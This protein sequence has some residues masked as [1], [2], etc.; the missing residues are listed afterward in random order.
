MDIFAV[1][2]HRIGEPSSVVKLALPDF[3]GHRALQ[4]RILS[5]QSRSGDPYGFMPWSADP[6]LYEVSDRQD[7]PRK[8]HHRRLQARRRIEG[9]DP[10][11]TMR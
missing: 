2:F 11:F 3:L 1:V 10:A 6:R 8:N 7:V 4:F 9:R 5:S